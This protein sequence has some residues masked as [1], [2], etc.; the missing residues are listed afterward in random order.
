MMFTKKFNN[1]KYVVLSGLRSIGDNK[2]GL[3]D[4]CIFSVKIEGQKLPLPR[5]MTTRAVAKVVEKAMEKSVSKVVE[6]AE[7]LS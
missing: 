7:K 3:I 4:F 1:Y 6:S 2:R 5:Y